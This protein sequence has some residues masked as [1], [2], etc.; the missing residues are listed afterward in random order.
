MN[1]RAL[2]RMMR[3]QHHRGPDAHGIW[4]DFAS[5]VGLAHNRLSILDVSESGNQPMNNAAGD[6]CVVFNGEIYNYLELRAELHDYPWRTKTDTEVLLA[7]YEQW[8][9]SCLQHLIGM[10]AFAIWDSR[11]NRLFAARD[12]FGVKPLY[13]HLTPEGGLYAASEIHALHAAGV[14]AECDV[15]SWATYLATGLH[16]HSARTFWKGVQSLPAGHSLTWQDG[17]L[18]IA[19][20][21]DLASRLGPGYDRRPLEQVAEEYEALLMDSV[22]LRFRSDVPVG[23]NLSGGLDS[24]TLLGL[25]HAIHG[26]DNDVKAFTYTCGDPRYDEL[27]WVRLM[28]QHTSHPSLV[29]RLRPE[30]VPDLA[31]S[32]QAHE[33]GPF[34]G[35]P[36]LAYARLFELAR[37]E[38]VV[39]LL[40]GQGMDEQWAGYEYYRQTQGSAVTGPVQGSRS[41]ALRPEC[42]VPEFRRLCEPLT[43]PR[44]F[45]DDLR[46]RQYL[47]TRFTKIPRALRFND[48]VSM[49]SSCELRE[50]FLDHRLFELAFSQPAGRKISPQ[51]QKW[52]LR[53]IT[54][55]LMPGEVVE[56]PKRP[57]QTPQREWVA[58]EL[59]DWTESCIETAVLELGGAWLEAARV[60]EAW[61]DYRT[62]HLDNS[63]AIWQW[64]SIGLMLQQRFAPVAL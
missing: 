44:P 27:P 58:N 29:Y 21:Y 43:A 63:F 25:V 10:F 3:T 2:E 13:Y 61:G 11:N 31:A 26:P 23:I 49:R 53:Q 47:D 52:M 34:G 4:M 12:R 60:R 37:S 38:G 62:K 46:N 22:R 45:P 59:R 32:V 42:L 15:T 14:P 50:P 54:R 6:L 48:R 18:K 55:R 57:V 17:N 40:D 39:V 41:Q 64:I 24:S 9:E 19:G 16:D 28:L 36:T 8:G 30:E 33:D 7:A 51:A 5:G 20:W 35:L 1:R 56:A